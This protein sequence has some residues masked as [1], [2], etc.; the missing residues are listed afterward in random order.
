MLSR[1]L[2]A[3][4]A[5]WIHPVD[6]LLFAHRQTCKIRR[7]EIH[8]SS[9]HKTERLC[10]NQIFVQAADIRLQ[11]EL[12]PFCIYIY[13]M[14]NPLV[15]PWFWVNSGWPRMCSVCQ[16]ASRTKSFCKNVKM[17]LAVPLCPD[18]KII[19]HCEC[20]SHVLMGLSHYALRDWHCSRG[21][22]GLPS[23]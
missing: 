11:K 16:Q 4:R 14:R 7:L 2:E 10:V 23:I 9:F 18:L 8:R 13:Q 19:S 15:N 20:L 5:S 6:L 22:P 12:S 21:M 3:L 1:R 17:N